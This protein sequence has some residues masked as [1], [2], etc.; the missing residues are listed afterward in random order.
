MA[1]L[2]E[3]LPYLSED[4]RLDHYTIET[5]YTSVWEEVTRPMKLP[6]GTFFANITQTL[7]PDLPDTFTILDLSLATKEVIL[8]NKWYDPGNPQMIIWPEP[9]R[10]IFNRA[11]TDVSYLADHLLPYIVDDTDP[12]VQNIDPLPNNQ[13]FIIKVVGEKPERGKA[14][15]KIKLDPAEKHG[16]FVI[17]PGLRTVLATDSRFPT[18]CLTFSFRSILA[19]TLGYIASHR[20]RLISPWD[21]E[22]IDVRE[23]PLGEAF[24]VQAF[25]RSQLGYCI[26]HCLAKVYYEDAWT[27]HLPSPQQ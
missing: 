9:Y 23:D 6:K 4:P 22:I 11:I 16:R 5:T 15:W 25:T 24:G 2:A 10:M 18:Y 17:A 3:L 7:C 21:T 20:Q 13:K 19:R 12:L 27:I 14:S 8:E 1:S 26:R